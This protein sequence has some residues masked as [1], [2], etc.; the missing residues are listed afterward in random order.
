MKGPAGDP[1]PHYA[2]ASGEA[3][4]LVVDK[5]RRLAPD[6]PAAYVTVA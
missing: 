4:K 1:L 2:I 6:D 5:S 3:G